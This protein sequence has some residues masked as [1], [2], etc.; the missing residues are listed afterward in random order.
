MSCYTVNHW[1]ETDFEELQCLKS[2]VVSS[3]TFPKKNCG[4]I[5]F[6]Y[7][8]LWITYE[9]QLQFFYWR[10]YSLWHIAPRS[11]TCI[12]NLSTRGVLWAV[13]IPLPR[14]LFLSFRDSFCH[15]AAEW[16]W[17]W[18]LLPRHWGAG[19]VVLAVRCPGLAA[20]SSGCCRPVPVVCVSVSQG[21]CVVWYTDMAMCLAWLNY[22]RSGFRQHEPLAGH[23]GGCW[24]GQLCLFTLCW[25]SWE[26]GYWQDG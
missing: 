19:M 11:A 9:C 6:V 7:R 16:A 8:M 12:T 26:M 2:Q 20:G 4:N 23:M 13:N 5:F 10:M 1:G 24:A 17:A 25:H 3:A 15:G 14:L 21:G 22:L 18:A